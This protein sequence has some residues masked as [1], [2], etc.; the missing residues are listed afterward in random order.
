MSGARIGLSSEAD[1]GSD[2]SHK[3]MQAMYSADPMMFKVSVVE[4]DAIWSLRQALE[5][6]C[7]CRPLGFWKKAILPTEECH[8]ICKLALVMTLSSS[9]RN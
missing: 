7:K 8:T 4:K 6:E 3:A 1:S 5:A 9:E 2:T